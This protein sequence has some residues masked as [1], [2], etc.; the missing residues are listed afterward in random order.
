MEK[1]K[2]LIVDDEPFILRVLK[3]KLE[4]GGYEVVTASNG[5]EAL[6]KMAQDPPAVLIT[7]INMPHMGGQELCRRLA[8]CSEQSPIFTI[9]VTSD[10]DRAIREWSAQSGNTRFVEKPFSPRKILAL[11]DGHFSPDDTVQ[12]GAGGAG[13]S[14]KRGG[15]Q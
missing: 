6:E 15:A 10:A 5:A 11:V 13:R 4:L 2:I 8:E 1:R 9:V 3:M 7:D 14:S 12:A